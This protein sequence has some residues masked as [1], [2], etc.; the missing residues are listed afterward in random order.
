MRLTHAKHTNLARSERTPSEH[1]GDPDGVHYHPRN[2]DC[3]VRRLFTDM[4]A[5][6]KR[7]YLSRE[8]RRTLDICVELTDSPQGRNETQDEGKTIRPAAR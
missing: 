6:V 2:S 3:G 8:I 5:A 7:A 1:S 4:H